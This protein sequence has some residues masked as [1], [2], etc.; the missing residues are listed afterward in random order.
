MKGP[1]QGATDAIAAHL[2]GLMA[3]HTAE[4]RAHLRPLLEQ[5]LAQA[6]SELKPEVVHV[7]Y[8]DLLKAAA[9]VTDAVGALEQARYTRGEIA[10]RQ[11]LERQARAL[12]KVLERFRK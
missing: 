1:A 7:V 8:P 10:A 5:Q 2:E 11:S 9:K 3:E 4:M 12:R 6:R